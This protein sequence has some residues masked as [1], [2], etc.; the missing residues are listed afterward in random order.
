M[1]M[2]FWDKLRARVQPEGI[3]WPGSVFY[4]L[5]SRSSVFQSHYALIA[6]GVAALCKE[7][8]LLDV[9]TGPGWLLIRIHAKCP[10]MRLSGVDISSAMA[11]RARRNVAA[12]KADGAIAIELGSVERLPFSDAAF[13]LVVSSVSAHH[14]KDA[15]GALNEI[16]RVLRPGGRALIYD[17]VKKLPEDVRKEA[18]RRFGRM[19]MAMIWA[20]SFEEHFYSAEE[21][22]A[23]A[24]ASP[25]REGSTSY[26]GFLCRLAMEKT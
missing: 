23:L 5:L 9:G 25:F 14:W 6:D 17:L 2:G 8:A 20:H 7:G 10:A 24:R 15:P 1:S 26:V 3:P 4:D 18:I 16:H 11:E 12:A 19:R 22:A 21:L 13:G